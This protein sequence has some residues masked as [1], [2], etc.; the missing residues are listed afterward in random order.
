MVGVMTWNNFQWRL[1]MLLFDCY[2]M[3]MGGDKKIS[4][5]CN[6]C[7]GAFV[8]HDFRLPFNSPTVNLMIPPS[9]FIEYVAN[10]KSFIGASWEEVDSTQKWPIVLLG[11]K[12][13]LNLI[14]Y[15]N[16][17]E[18]EVAWRRR[19]KRINFER[20]YFVLIETDGCTY[21]D[22]CRFDCLPYPHKIA[23]THKSYPD[24]KCSYVVKGYK[25][26]GAVIDSYRFFKILPF[27]KYDQ[28]NW[29]KF[30]KQV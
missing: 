19:E 6:N 8:A 22:L 27:R 25:D 7:I 3:L 29:M 12:I 17:F 28:F 2:Q 11:G 24:I 20:M 16:S 5:F 30:L 1:R 13:H 18:G 23:L 21:E 10:L 14:H 4:I 15:K 9:E 26:L